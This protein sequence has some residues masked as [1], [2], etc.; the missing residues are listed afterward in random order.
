MRAKNLIN[1][2]IL[3]DYYIKMVMTSG[4]SLHF[5]SCN[6]IFNQLT[7]FSGDGSD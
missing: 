3:E 5:G 6:D 1:A 7:F 2:E 4:I